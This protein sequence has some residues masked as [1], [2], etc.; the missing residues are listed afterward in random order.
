MCGL[1][2]VT[3][4]AGGQIAGYNL[5]LPSISVGNVLGA[6]TVTRS[7]T[8][9][10]ATPATYAP[11]GGITG[12]SMSVSP[13]SLVVQP[14]ET[15]S[16]NL[17]LTRTTA[18]NNVWQFGSL[19]WSDGAGHVVR[20]PVV[21]RSGQPVIAPGLI[22]V[23][24]AAASKAF[25][26]QTGFTGALKTVLGGLKEIT[27]ASDTVAQAV[28]ST[29]SSNALIQSACSAG[30]SGTKVTSVTIPAGTLYAQWE[31]FDRDTDAGLGRTDLDLAVL[32]PAGTLVALSGG[33]TANEFVS[34]TAPAAGTYKVCV[35]GYSTVDGHSSN[36]AMSSVV[37][38]S[39]DKGG[40]FK[41]LVPAKVYAGSS[42]SVNASWSG[43]AA[44]KRYIG[45]VQM[46]DLNGAP[47]A[48]TV[49]KV[50]TNNPIPLGEPV[51]RAVVQQDSA[52]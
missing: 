5:N 25:A 11:S 36:Y 16:F 30:I 48:T 10:G 22:T 28:G 52:I 43:L 3:N 45:A 34:L 31:L 13:T 18:A 37:V 8:N 23:P 47:A 27:K 6:V 20:M 39:A 26:V 21:A 38:N 2:V 29:V 19:S 44:G 1:G 4:C 24:K 33:N 50:E 46:Q 40:N 15:K 14:G 7:V 35:I 51:P 49:F 42:A 32:N 12:F 41:V 17:T 9:V